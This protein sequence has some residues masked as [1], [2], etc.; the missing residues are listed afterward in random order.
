[1]SGSDVDVAR[2]GSLWWLWLGVALAYL[3][4]AGGTLGTGDASATFALARSIVDRGRVDV[5]RDQSLD[6]WRGPDGRYYLP[7]GIGQALYDVPFLV[8]GRVALGVAGVPAAQQEPFLKAGVALAS[9]VSA[10]LC[11]AAV[12][13]LAW[14]FSRNRSAAFV[15]GLIA[16]FATPLWPYSKFGFS[17][18]LVAAAV[19]SGVLGLAAGLEDERPGW[20]IGGGALL[21]AA[22]LVRHEAVLAIGAA[23]GWVALQPGAW[24]TRVF[25]IGVASVG[26]LTASVGSLAYNVARFGNPWRT[27][28]TPDVT[29][30]GAWGLLA[31]PSGSIVVFAPIVVI[32]IL[33]LVSA[34]RKRQP[35]A[36]LVAVVAGVLT[37]FYASLDDYLGT[38]SYGPRYLVPL[39]PLVVAPIAAWVAPDPAHVWRRRAVVAVAV[40]SLLIQIPAV[41]V[42]FSRAGIAAGRPVPALRVTEWQWSPLWITTRAAAHGVADNLRYVTGLEP[43]P[44]GD[45]GTDD[46]SLAARV[47][48]SLDF[49]WLYAWYLG[50]ISRATALAAAGL[51][52]AGSAACLATGWRSA[53]G[54]VGDVP[55]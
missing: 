29:W 20:M 11:V 49:W 48:F 26:P 28:H 25:R 53:M 17:A 22:V 38:R 36:W 8:A 6:A 10:S 5:P 3:L 55:G 32:G 27:G 31:S 51:L 7:F 42:D 43:R 52:A 40:L 50:L 15:T 23:L 39:V 30:R 14:R 44:R 34:V 9:T 13:A 19:A 33:A 45:H 21:G 35:L 1:M 4:T 16:A 18:P 24:K 2:R 54:R 12:A 41:L 47:S 46:G 37:V